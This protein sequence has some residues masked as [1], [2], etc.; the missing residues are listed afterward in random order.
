MEVAEHARRTVPFYGDAYGSQRFRDLCEVPLVDKA[1]MRAAPPGALLVAEPPPGSR[2]QRTSG[3]TGVP[4]EAVYSARFARWQGLLK[5]RTDLERGVRPWTKR[6]SFVFGTGDLR[7]K[8]PVVRWSDGR[9]LALSLQ[10]DTDEL[11][12]LIDRWRPR[13][14]A[15]HPSRL[16]DVGARLPDAAKP[17]VLS[18]FGETLEPTLRRGLESV[19]GC[20]PLDSYGTAEVGAVA[21]QCPRADLYHVQIESLVLEVLDREDRP[22]APG[23]SGN[24][25]LTGLHNPLMP[26]VRYRMHD[27]ATLADRPCACG[28]TGQCLVAIVGRSSDFAVGAAGERI[29]PE[30]L[31]LYSHLDH[32][33]VWRHVRRYQIHQQRDGEIVVRLELRE[34]LGARLEAEVL[35]SYRRDAAGQAVSLR[36]EDDLGEREPGKFRLVRSDAPPPG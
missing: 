2:T 31:W 15:G 9:H 5:L 36:V 18:T 35:A 17:T 27:R 8:P 4:F 6:A 22:V 11:A 10:G 20:A 14:L 16:L 1:A 28:Y 32:D 3:T 33:L 34:P 21:R 7:P 29:S 30:R 25:V 24:V 12:A 13:S 26:M 23:D 19:Y